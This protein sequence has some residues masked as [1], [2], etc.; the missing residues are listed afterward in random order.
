V[1]D[2]DMAHYNNRKALAKQISQEQMLH[3]SE[4]L[5]PNLIAS[6]VLT[7]YQNTDMTIDEIHYLCSQV[8]E[9]WVRSTDE[10][11]NI[12]ENCYELTGVDVRRYSD[13]G[14]I[15]YDEKYRPMTMAQRAERVRKER[16]QGDL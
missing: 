2:A 8:E 9:L 16:M 11:W 10:G 14:T 12:R 15:I 4:Y 5:T 7:L 6:F 1:G 13:T 3:I